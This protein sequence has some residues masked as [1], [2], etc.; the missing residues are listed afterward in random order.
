MKIAIEIYAV[1]R[2]VDPLADLDETLRPLF[3]MDSRAS[4]GGRQALLRLWHHQ[5]PLLP[6]LRARLQALDLEV[7]EYYSVKLEPGEGSES[8]YSINAPVIRDA[9]VVGDVGAKTVVCTCGL[10]P[11]RLTGEAQLDLELPD[12][13]L[14]DIFCTPGL[15]V[16]I[17][18]QSLLAELASEGLAEGL[19]RTPV[20]VN[21]SESP[22]WVAIHSDVSLGW[23][24]APFGTTTETCPVCGGATPKFWL[25]HIYDEVAPVPPWSHTELHG[26]RSL[27]VSRA[28]RDRL[29]DVPGCTFL[30]SGW[31]PEDREFAFLPESLRP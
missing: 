31:D 30:R 5:L 27:Y 1:G 7:E 10:R 8:S 15:G 6:A 29:A 25:L 2:K 24:S 28:V 19:V 3:V 12:R 13:D 20:V 23:P 16:P 22:E 14:P 17:I 18:R 11:V 4:E 9:R 26:P 21:G